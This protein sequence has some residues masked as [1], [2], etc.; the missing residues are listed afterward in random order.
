MNPYSD[1]F[2]TA[3]PKV[4][5]V[6][7]RKVRETVNDLPGVAG[8]SVV[9]PAAKGRGRPKV[10]K[11]PP[12]ELASEEV[13]N[14]MDVERPMSV[15]E[16]A[17][18]K[19]EV[20][21]T[22]AIL[23]LGDEA[24]S[25]LKPDESNKEKLMKV[26]NKKVE[27]IEKH[28]AKLV[29]KLKSGKGAKM[30]KAKAAPKGK[31]KAAPKAKATKKAMHEEAK[32]LESSL[33]KTMEMI[34]KVEKEMKPKKERKPRA[35]KPFSER[36]I[37]YKASSDVRK[38]MAAAKKAKKAEE[39]KKSQML[40]KEAKDAVERAKSDLRFARAMKLKDIEV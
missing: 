17:V 24:R 37:D 2:V 31:A 4:K 32:E 11:M 36:S 12:V 40:L 1:E 27:A 29:E 19:H 14:V 7:T 35:E 18:A 5:T 20:E 26:Y 15:M 34:N 39:I 8:D 30:E 28:H 13:K 6:R 38:G 22:K 33:K 23:K 10:V 16:K 21:K 9:V 25:K 3:A